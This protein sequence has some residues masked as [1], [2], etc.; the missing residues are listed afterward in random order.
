[1]RALAEDIDVPLLPASW[2]TRL[3]ARFVDE[4]AAMLEKVRRHNC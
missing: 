2:K 4:M 3:C 1:M